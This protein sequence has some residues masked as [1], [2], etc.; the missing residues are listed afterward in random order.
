MLV[1]GALLLLAIAAVY[2]RAVGFGFVNYDDPTFVLDNPQVHGFSMAH[3]RWAFSSIYIYWQPLTWISYMADWELFR[4]SPAGYHLTNLLL[5]GASTILL[6]L[7]LRRMTGAPAASAFVAALFALHPLHVESAVWIAE[8]KGLLSGLFWTLSLLAYSWYVERPSAWRML[9]VIVC[10][11]LGLMSKSIV[12]TLPCL[13]L[14]LD[15][16]PLGRIAGVGW[17]GALARPLPK[18]S[19]PRLLLE[20]APLLGLAALS[21]I[22]TVLAQRRMGAVNSLEM[23]PIPMRVQQAVV[24]FAEYVRKM[25]WPMDLAVFY[26]NP[27][28]WSIWLVGASA[29]LLG[30]ITALAVREFR[31]KPYLIVGWLWFLGVLFPV[32]GLFQAGEQAMADRYTYLALTGLSV[33]VVWAAIDFCREAKVNAWV[34]RS[35]AV[36]TLAICSILSWFQVQT[37]SSTQALFE[38]ANA[39]TRGNYL[40]D[41]VLGRI[42]VDEGKFDQAIPLLRSALQVQPYYAATHHALGDAFA[43]KSDFTDAIEHYNAAL[44]ADPGNPAI[45]QRRSEAYAASGRWEAAAADCD[46]LLNAAPNS[47]AAEFLMASICQ[48]QRHYPEALRHYRKT[49]Q[50]NPAQPIALNNAAWILATYTNSALRNGAEALQMAQRA[51][52]LTGHRVPMFLGTLAGA[53]AELGEFP[54]AIHTAEQA[55]DLARAAGQ[56]ELTERNAQLLGLYRAGKPCRDPSP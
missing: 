11:G 31:P 1:V 33:M 7:A 50:L 14:L 8:R 5:H 38:H 18:R 56:K 30:V 26:P 41:T 27:Y 28:Q 53:Q 32:S 44:K 25:F 3:L 45:R 35:A 36:A 21:S 47:P 49:L 39:V 24:C 40:A 42:L 54:A 9:S 23:L 20:K 37:W 13:L 4:L 10:F 12:V 17:T 48:G 52:D 2:G 51:C 6:W 19:L 43:G 29:L 22:L 46:A 34:P 55:R 16:W 15:Y